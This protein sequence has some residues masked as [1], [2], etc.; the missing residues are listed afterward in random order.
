MAKTT[1]HYISFVKYFSQCCINLMYLRLFPVYLKTRDEACS[2]FML[3]I[4]ENRT[5]LDLKYPVLKLWCFGPSN[6]N[7]TYI[8]CPCTT[9]QTSRR[10]WFMIRI[11]LHL[12]GLSI[13]YY[14][15]FANLSFI[16]IAWEYNTVQHLLLIYLFQFIMGYMWFYTWELR[17]LYLVNIY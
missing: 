11:H 14:V 1:S 2:I 16:G 9:H 12:S 8:G 10:Y 4:R 13:M 15:T 17:L 6:K 5:F 7:I 3:P